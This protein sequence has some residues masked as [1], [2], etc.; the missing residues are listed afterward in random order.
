L[1]GS[2]TP[3]GCDVGESAHQRRSGPDL[4]P[5]HDRFH[6]TAIVRSRR[7]GIAAFALDGKPDFRLHAE[8]IHGFQAAFALRPERRKNEVIMNHTLHLDLLLA[9]A[10]FVGAR[11]AGLMVF[12][13]FLGSTA[14]PRPVKAVTAVTVTALL[15]PLH[16]PVRLEIHAWA[17]A[18]IMISEAVIGLVLGIAANFMLEAP[19]LAGQLLG[20]QMGYSLATLFDPQTQADTP[21]LAEFHR[22][23][24]LLIFLQLDVHHWILRAVVHSFSYMPA[25]AWLGASV[26]VLLLRAAG[27]IFLCGVQIAAPA[28]IATILVDVSLG[29]LGKASPQLPVLFVGLSIKNLLGLAMLMG[30][31]AF[32]PQTFSR[33]FSE[34]V[35]FGERLLQ[36]APR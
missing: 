29:F 17:W 5:G 33:H 21:V 24:A 36:L 12:C 27:T 6:R 32:W 20:V 31:V 2:A 35:R 8:N 1:D 3:A 34:S 14:I 4:S 18:V 26:G 23:A 15:Y 19:I 10:V 7:G 16:S 9:A 11:V 30:V 22:M 28:L 25:G 13:P